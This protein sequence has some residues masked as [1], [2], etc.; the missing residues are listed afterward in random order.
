MA[1]CGCSGNCTC[2]IELSCGCV[3][4]GRLCPGNVDTSWFTIEGMTCSSCVEMITHLLEVP[5]RVCSVSRGGLFSFLPDATR[6]GATSGGGRGGGGGEGTVLGATCS[7]CPLQAKW[8]PKRL[9]VSLS[10]SLGGIWWAGSKPKAQEVSE[11]LIQHTPSNATT[12][13]H[14]RAERPWLHGQRAWPSFK[15]GPEPSVWLT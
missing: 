4:Y 2:S 1:A 11:A 7:A 14:R 10:Q 5:P 15:R 9:V 8:H 12:T 3:S 6:S 13:G